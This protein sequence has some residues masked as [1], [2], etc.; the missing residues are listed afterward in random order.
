MFF[1]FCFGYTLNMF[2][3]IEILLLLLILI[4]D[5]PVL[6]YLSIVLCFLEARKYQKN[7]YPLLLILIADVFLLTFWHIEIG[8]F[9]FCVVQC[10]YGYLINHKSHFYVLIICLVSFEWMITIYVMLS[11]INMCKSY[12]SNHWLFSVLVCLALCDIC[13]A[14]QYLFHISIP[15]LWCFYLLSQI[16][17]VKKAPNEVGTIVKVNKRSLH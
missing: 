15:L 2:I 7:I 5:H 16:L 11:I 4:F 17:Y 3:Y 10:L 9:F 13:V 6:K 1:S 12:K 8:I 14:L